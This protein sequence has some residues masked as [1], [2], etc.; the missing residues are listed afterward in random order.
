MHNQLF[1][2]ALGIGTPWSVKSVAKLYAM[3]TPEV[4]FIRT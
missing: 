2:S 3:H 4:E 1:E